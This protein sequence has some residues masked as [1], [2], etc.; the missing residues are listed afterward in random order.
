[1]KNPA[2]F[3]AAVGRALEALQP[4]G[5]LLLAVSGGADSVALADAVARARSRRALRDIQLVVGHVDHRLR[6]DS[7]RDEAISRRHAERLGLAFVSRAI[8][9]RTAG[10]GLEQAAREA[11]YDALARMA[12]ETGCAGI[13][14]G[15]TATDQAETLLWRLVRGTGTRGLGG[16]RPVREL[17]VLELFRPLLG[18]T[19]E[20]TRAWCERSGLEFRDDPTNLDDRPRAVL[21][22]EVLPELER[23]QPGAVLRLAAAADRLREDDAAL[24][25]LAGGADDRVEALKSLPASVKKRA[26]AQILEQTVGTRRRV[27]AAHLE[28]L[29]RLLWSGRGEVDLPSA[30]GRRAVA[31]VDGGR[32]VVRTIERAMPG[33]GRRAAA[34]RPSHARE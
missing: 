23:L 19:R 1:M 32:L 18:V 6:S 25:M 2:D 21:R 28:S 15:H 9:V 22:R 29:E 16:M 13:A 10:S 11:R 34:R 30:A 17:G 12:G 20:Q 26:L 3:V 31:R 24:E 8:R 5:T 27:T 33:K 14:T 4:P 7:A